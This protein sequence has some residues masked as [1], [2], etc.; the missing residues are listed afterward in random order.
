MCSPIY[1][2]EYNEKDKLNQ[3]SSSACKNYN[4]NSTVFSN[5]PQYYNKQK[6]NFQPQNSYK[7]QYTPHQTLAHLQNN[8]EYEQIPLISLSPIPSHSEISPTH[9]KYNCLNN[10][11]N[12]AINNSLNMF[13]AQSNDYYYPQP[14]YSQNSNNQSVFLNQKNIP[15]T[16]HRFNSPM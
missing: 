16:Y 13:L 3:K 8:T 10:L 9:L 2:S 15:E 4:N 1:I 11:E 14:Y 7:S 5:Q 6:N 12:N